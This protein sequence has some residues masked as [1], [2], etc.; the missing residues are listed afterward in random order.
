MKC[1][2]KLVVALFILYGCG[3]LPYDW[4]RPD[5]PPAVMEQ[6]KK[7]CKEYT[8]RMMDDKWDQLVRS[9]I[10]P[11]PLQGDLAV[12]GI[13]IER[14]CLESKGY[15]Y[16]ALDPAKV[17]HSD[18]IKRDAQG[19]VSFKV[20]ETGEDVIF[21][22]RGTPKMSYSFNAANKDYKI[23]V[24]D[25]LEDKM[26]NVKSDAILLEFDPTYGI[27]VFKAMDKLPRIRRDD[28]PFPPDIKQ[29]ALGKI[30]T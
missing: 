30:S 8:N 5:T 9:G 19:K 12:E 3:G 28:A 22:V 17:S 10:N 13:E 18:E 7:E 21:Q 26:F 16:Q 4:V 1:Y 24:Y 6:D 20:G 2:P 29:W 11:E 27:Y 25:E 15:K 23:L 14:A